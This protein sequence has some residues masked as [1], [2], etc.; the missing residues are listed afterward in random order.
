[1]T[2]LTPERLAEIEARTL[3]CSITGYVQLYARDVL[4]LVAAAKANAQLVE[5]LRYGAGSAINELTAR[6]LPPEWSPESGIGKML[7][8]LGCHETRLN[9]TV[10]SALSG[11]I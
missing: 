3:G 10:R 6:S 8:A 4:A 1:M 5:A 7:S 9:D 11:Q 2:A